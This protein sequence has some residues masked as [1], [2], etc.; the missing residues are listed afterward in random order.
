M[1]NL[2]F[3]AAAVAATLALAISAPVHSEDAPVNADQNSG[4]NSG[5]IPGTQYLITKFPYSTFNFP[6]LA[7]AED[8]GT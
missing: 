8:S 3:G 6:A 7:K 4:G 5:A 1:R 2:F